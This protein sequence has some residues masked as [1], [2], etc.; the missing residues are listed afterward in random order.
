[1]ENQNETQAKVESSP[2]NGG[3]YAEKVEAA[4]EDAKKKAFQKKAEKA[5]AQIKVSDVE[6]KFG[7][8]M[9][10]L[11]ANDAYKAMESFET[12]QISDAVGKAFDPPNPAWFASQDFGEQMAFKKGFI[13]GLQVLRLARNQL[14]NLILQNQAEQARKDGQEA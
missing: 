10:P 9:L 2:N 13:I 1:M 7:M 4:K 6:M 8:A 14:L 3:S 11:L 5:P 12:H